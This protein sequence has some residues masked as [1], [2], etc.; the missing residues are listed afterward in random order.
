MASLGGLVRAVGRPFGGLRRWFAR[1]PL[2]TAALI[3][4]CRS[5]R[6]FLSSGMT[7]REGMESLADKGTF[8]V[9]GVAR[10]LADE[11]ADGWTFEDA[12]NKQG[13]RF[14]VLFTALVAVG[15]ETGRLPEVMHD[16]ERYYEHQQQQQRE[17]VGQVT[18][19]VLQY[20]LAAVVVAGLIFILSFIGSTKTSGGTKRQVVY[21]KDEKGRNT[22][23]PLLD[24]RGEPVTAELP[25]AYDPLGWGLV[26][27]EGAYTFLAIAL[28][29]PVALWLLFRLTRWLLRGGAVVDRIVLAVPLVGG[30]ARA[31]AL[32]RY[33][34][35][36]ALML[37]SSMSIL[38]SIRLGFAAT[39]NAAFAAAGPPAEANLRRGNTIVSS[40]EQSRLFPAAYLSAAAVGEQTGHL[41]EVMKH[42]AVYYDEIARRRIG[43]L[44]TIAGY[45]V[46]IGVAA[47]IAMLV[48]RLFS[49]YIEMIEKVTPK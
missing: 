19:P 14:P 10:E 12:L 43:T 38:K 9:R 49:T 13:K 28:G 36:M 6:F 11:L 35:A 3:E 20:V 37:D 15:E 42:Q 40:I 8:R 26:G 5:I 17:L 25:T 23:R 46:W 1:R 47:F 44:Y 39:G 31:L 32:T 24:S 2:S 45:L 4:F 22:D 34:F 41:P 27:E 18:K 21:E 33:S 30:C 16:L 7:L 29:V 48:I